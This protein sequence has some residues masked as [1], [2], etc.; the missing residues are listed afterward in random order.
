MINITRPKKQMG[1]KR[2][3]LLMG[4]VLFQQAAIISELKGSDQIKKQNI[5]LSRERIKYWAL[6]LAVTGAYQC[7]GDN[8]I[9]IVSIF[10]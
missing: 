9:F 4:Q 3:I 5:E 6:Y 7:S 8:L 2:K 10:L 1:T